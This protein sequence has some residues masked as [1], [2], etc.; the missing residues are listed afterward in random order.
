MYITGLAFHL[1]F[2]FRLSTWQLCT[3]P[4]DTHLEAVKWRSGCFKKEQQQ[5]KELSCFWFFSSFLLFFSFS[6]VFLK[7]EISERSFS[8]FIFIHH[9]TLINV[10][11][12]LLIFFVRLFIRNFSTLSLSL[13]LFVAFFFIFN[14]WRENLRCFVRG[15]QQEKKNFIEFSAFFLLVKFAFLILYFNDSLNM[16]VK[17]SICLLSVVT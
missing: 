10:L 9:R 3:V 6:K 13:G 2:L 4:N 12:T 7:I 11:T 16:C 8:F 14:G 5:W 1:D 17:Q 15:E